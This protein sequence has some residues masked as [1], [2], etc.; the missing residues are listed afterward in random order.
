MV[1]NIARNG[2]SFRGAGAY[3]LHDKPGPG[4]VRPRTAARVAFTATRNLANEDPHAALDEMWRTARDAAYLK[5]A[6]APS[7]PGAGMPRP[8]RP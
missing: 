6:T 3:H 8:S 2:S 5:A 4:E 7:P 1:P